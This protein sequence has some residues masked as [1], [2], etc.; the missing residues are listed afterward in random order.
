[1]KLR[2]AYLMQ[3]LFALV[4]AVSLSFGAKQVFASEGAALA[5]CPAKGFDYYYAPCANSCAI[6]RGYCDA[7]G[8]CQCGSL[9]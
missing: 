9:P 8:N 7:D 6:K 1:M 5:T 3:A 2:M 4:I